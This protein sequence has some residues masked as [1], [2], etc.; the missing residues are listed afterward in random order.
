M[1]CEREPCNAADRNLT[2]QRALGV[3]NPILRF[4]VLSNQHRKKTQ[5]TTHYYS[6]LRHVLFSNRKYFAVLKVRCRKIFVRFIFGFME[7]SENILTPKFSQ[8]T[9]YFVNNILTLVASSDFL[10][11]ICSNLFFIPAVLLKLDYFVCT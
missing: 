5:Q 2:R 3:R 11:T 8:F 10:R 6:E 1:L 4:E 7:A 9:V